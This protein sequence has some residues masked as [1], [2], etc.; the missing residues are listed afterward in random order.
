[1][2][3][4]SRSSTLAYDHSQSQPS[5]AFHH[6]PPQGLVRVTPSGPRA[7]IS[8]DK[9]GAMSTY[10]WSLAP[11]VAL[12]IYARIVD[13]EL[14][15]LRREFT[16]KLDELERQLR[17]EREREKD[18]VFLW[19]KFAEL[20]KRGMSYDD[21]WSEALVCLKKRQDIRLA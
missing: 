2:T 6:Q 7:N 14:N 16:T 12:F 15:K 13:G 20:Q 11:F 21:A 3:S 5:K 4:P 1:V 8:S 19:E 17:E 18:N 9:G 10:L